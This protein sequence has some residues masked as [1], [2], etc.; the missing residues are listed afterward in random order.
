MGVAASS[1]GIVFVADTYNSAVEEILVGRKFGPVNVGSANTNPVSLYFTFGASGA[2][3]STSVLTQGAP[4]LDFTDAGYDTCTA[5]EAY[6]AGETCGVN[7]TFKPEAPGPRSGAAELVDTSGNVLATGDLQGTGIG[8]LVNFM[9][10]TLSQAVSH[11]AFGRPV[12]VAVDASSNL[13]IADAAH[14]EVYEFLAKSGYI[15]FNQLGPGFLN[16]QGRCGG[17]ERE[18]LRHRWRHRCGV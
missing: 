3:G 2:L 10:D 18:R 6:S 15:I 11:Y 5:N 14:Y 7:V 12:A 13:Y 4:G 17:R 16:P 1:G 9:P 8:P